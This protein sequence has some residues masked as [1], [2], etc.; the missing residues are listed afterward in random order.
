MTLCFSPLTFL[1]FLSS[2][3]GADPDVDESVRL[4]LVF[5]VCVRTRRERQREREKRELF[6]QLCWGA[7]NTQ[8]THTRQV[9]VITVLPSGG[10][11]FQS[12]SRPLELFWLT[13][14]YT[15]DS[16]REGER[17]REGEGRGGRSAACGRRRRRE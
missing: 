6:R 13:L 17:V 11:T 5:G 10:F 9:L 14:L 1:L 2:K 12:S 3:G 15:S 4:F 8:G 16:E 7:L